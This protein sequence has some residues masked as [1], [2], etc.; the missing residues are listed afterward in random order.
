[1]QIS[2]L[3]VNLAKVLI[4][5]DS[6]KDDFRLSRLLI[7]LLPSDNLDKNDWRRFKLALI[8][9][10]ESLLK[11]DQTCL[12][13][14]LRQSRFYRRLSSILNRFWCIIPLSWR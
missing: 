4:G 14:D 7:S 8:L 3:R 13:L 11:Q 2:Y 1:M 9:L 6:K 10:L 12:K 5:L